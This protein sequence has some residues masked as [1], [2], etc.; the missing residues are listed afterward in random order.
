MRI[1]PYFKWFD[2]WI[3]LFY[4]INKKILY[5]GLIPMIGLKIIF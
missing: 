5:I 1:K 2:F 3:G 4:D